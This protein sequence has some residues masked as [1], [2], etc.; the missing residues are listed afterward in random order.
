MFVS[1]PDFRNFCGLVAQ[2]HIVIIIFNTSWAILFYECHVVHE[3][4]DILTK[5][6]LAAS[7]VAYHLS[8]YN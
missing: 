8:H 3:I 2:S 7:D 5:H 1:L 4:N 6:G